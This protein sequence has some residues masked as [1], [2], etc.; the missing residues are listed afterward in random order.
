MRYGI[1][2]GILWGLDTVIPGIALT[3]RPYVGTAEALA[4]A[5]IASSLLHDAFAPSGSI[6][7]WAREGACAIPGT[8]LGPEVDS[9]SRSEPYSAA[10]SE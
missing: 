5:A 9:W 6:A 8:R 10:P 4:F 2:S 1:L 7:T 3:M